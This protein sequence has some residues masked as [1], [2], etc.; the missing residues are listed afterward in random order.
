MFGDTLKNGNPNEVISL[1][2]YCKLSG[3]GL[4]ISVTESKMT[5]GVQAF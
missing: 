1:L 2:E 4:A 5:N 3:S